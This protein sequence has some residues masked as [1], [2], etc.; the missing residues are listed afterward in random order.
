MVERVLG[1]KDREADETAL[2]WILSELDLKIA[3]KRRLDYVLVSHEIEV[4]SKAT[5]VSDH[6]DHRPLLVELG[7]R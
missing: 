1:K 4:I 2:N 5:L 3:I 6:S 7:I